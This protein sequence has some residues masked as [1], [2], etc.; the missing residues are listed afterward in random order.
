MGGHLCERCGRCFDSARG[1]G[2]HLSASHPGTPHLVTCRTCGKRRRLW[3][4]SMCRRCCDKVRHAPRTCREC[5]EVKRHHSSGRCARCHRR[6]ST[7]SASPCSDCLS[8]GPIVG[9][10]CSACRQF[11]AKN[12]VGICVMCGRRLATAKGGRCRL[13]LIAHRASGSSDGL[14]SEC[15]TW[16]PLI[17]RGCCKTC[18]MFRFRGEIGVC[19]VCGHEVVVGRLR[20]CRRCLVAGA[21]AGRRF[22][23]RPIDQARP[24]P[25]LA[26]SPRAIQLFFTGMLNAGRNSRPTAHIERDRAPRRTC[27][28]RGQLNLLWVPADPSRIDVDEVV[29]AAT[30]ELPD[31]FPSVAAF[32]A[33]RG[34]IETTV[35]GVQRATAVLLAARFE[36]DR[37]EHSSLQ[38]LG[39]LG[40][41]VGSTVDFLSDTGLLRID[42]DA[43]LDAWLDERLSGLPGKIRIEVQ[44]WVDVLRGRSARRGKPH[45]PSTIKV[46]VKVTGPVLEQWSRRYDSLRRVTDQDVEK[47]LAG[48]EGWDRPNLLVGM[49]SLFRTLKANRLIFADP[50]AGFSVEA[51]SRRPPLALDPQ[52]RS[53]LL[54]LIHRSDHRL[55]ALLA[56]VHALSCKQMA[57][58]R[59]DDVDLSGDRFFVNGRPRPLDALTREQLVAWLDF[60]RATW[61]H[62]ANPHLLVTSKSAARLVPAGQTFIKAAVAGLPITLSGLRTDRLVCE[63]LDSGGDA[64]RIALM[65]GLSTEA[66]TGYA[67]S[68]GPFDLNPG[69]AMFDELSRGSQRL[70]S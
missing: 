63:A 3:A 1:L 11:R 33:T 6:A 20:R 19:R 56:G 32:G 27:L 61:P 51:P 40:L 12:R 2:S 29:A 46:Y 5:G 22:P 26:A 70:E 69:N 65:F 50:T 54:G 67:E 21:R 58:L 37:F 64:L 68:C 30:A 16:A 43:T 17:A 18:I 14:C 53:S 66:A 55:I 41:P 13:C 47:Q 57:D 36:Q 59:V 49:R 35:R 45:Q 8:W 42:P 62:T 15:G 38:C 25:K 39:A 23:G 34:W 52:V 9:A 48:L 60:R 31:L 10:L 24:P 4:N 44:S 28:T 7:K